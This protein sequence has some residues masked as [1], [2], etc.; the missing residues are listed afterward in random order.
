MNDR[1]IKTI[2][3][4]CRDLQD[5][6][7]QL[8]HYTDRES[9]DIVVVRCMLGQLNDLVKEIEKIWDK[10]NAKMKKEENND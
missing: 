2:E 6:I 7:R 1:K 9:F 8:Y 3:V 10:A 4:D 5:E